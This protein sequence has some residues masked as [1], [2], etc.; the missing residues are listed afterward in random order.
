[1]ITNIVNFQLYS[2]GDGENLKIFRQFLK[3]STKFQIKNYDVSAEI[4]QRFI[5][6][7][8]YRKLPFFT[9]F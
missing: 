6:Y 8:K 9:K 4:S 2:I 1:M 7:L 5:F 3:F